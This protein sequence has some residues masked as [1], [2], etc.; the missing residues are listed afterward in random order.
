M[1]SS[2]KKSEVQILEDYRV[3][4][5][6]AVN[7]TEIANTLAEFGYDSSEISKGTALLAATNTAYEANKQEDNETIAS[8]ADFDN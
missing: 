7:Q 5:T 4:L 2:K 3:A 6:N 8:R 1:V